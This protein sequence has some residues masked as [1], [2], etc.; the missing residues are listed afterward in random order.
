MLG[1]LLHPFRRDIPSLLI[2][3]E[4]FPASAD[5]LACTDEGVGHELDRQ[6][7][8]IRSLISLNVP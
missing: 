8:Y 4:L 1:T 5:Q 6:T 7:G 2:K 3:V